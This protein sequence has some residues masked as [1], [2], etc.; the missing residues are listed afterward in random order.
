[1]RVSLSS[2]RCAHQEYSSSIQWT[3]QEKKMSSWYIGNIILR[4]V[5]NEDSDLNSV[6]NVTF[7]S[8]CS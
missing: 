5:Y 2:F 3:I 8:R 6:S 4:I 1:M 7:V